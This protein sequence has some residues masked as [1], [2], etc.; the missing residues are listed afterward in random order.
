MKAK[1]QANDVASGSAD[2][3]LNTNVAAVGGSKKRKTGKRRHIIDSEDERC[4]SRGP[5]P[6]VTVVT[7]LCMRQA[8]TCIYNCSC[9]WCGC[10][11]PITRY[12]SASVVQHFQ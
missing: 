10:D 11:K 6:S 12:S 3:D 9:P 1:S 2:S 8:Q 5:A 4:W 7:P